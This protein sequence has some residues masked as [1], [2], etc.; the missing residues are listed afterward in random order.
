MPYPQKLSEEQI[1]A[2]ATRLVDEAGLDALSARVLAR[3]LGAR[4]PSLYRYFP[5][6]ESL[7]CALSAGFLESLA[8]EVDRHESLAGMARA[9][10]DYAL[11]H[12]NRYAVVVCR[13]PDA[14]RSPAAD[15]FQ[16]LAA[17]LGLD[18]PPVV[19]RVLW[20]YLHGAVGVRVLWPTRDDLD[21]EEA[22]AAGLT[23]FEAWLAAGDDGD[24]ADRVPPPRKGSRSSLPSGGVSPAASPR[25]P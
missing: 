8:R 4:A 10:W 21:L 1:L 23:A 25:F 3:R 16:E 14:A 24:R 17:R 13:P 11:R 18:R 19:A 15:R 20:S 6:M 9:Y 5:D 12:P 22:F 7:V 2:E